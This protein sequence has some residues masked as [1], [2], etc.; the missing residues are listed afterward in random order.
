MDVRV[1]DV[2]ESDAEG[3]VVILN[4]IIE[5]GEYT[6][7]DAP[8]TVEYERGYIANFP[9]R[10]VFCVAED[11]ED[12]RIVGFQSLEP[13]ATYT[14][15]FD[16]VGVMGTFVD[17]TCRCCGVGTT[18]AKYTFGMATRHGYEKIFTYV[19]V[20]NIDSL[21]FHLKLGFRIVGTAYRQA[22]IG[23]MYVDEV[24]IEK[25]L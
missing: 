8:L 18:L 9:Q 19:R 4:P 3:I 6:V 23:Y 21:A 10:G 13:Y 17:L 15:A 11:V 24:V 12:G 2:Q 25:F 14:R 22:R 1:R 5:A 20:D 16:H 7:L